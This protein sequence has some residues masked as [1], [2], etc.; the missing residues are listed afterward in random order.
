MEW[1]TG[2]IL[3]NG[4]LIF[5]DNNIEVDSYVKHKKNCVHSSG[6]EVA[7][8]DD[9]LALASIDILYGFGPSCGNS[10]ILSTSPLQKYSSGN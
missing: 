3:V 6:R 1:S 7:S 9:C 2:P 4:F 10:V 5:V 8:M